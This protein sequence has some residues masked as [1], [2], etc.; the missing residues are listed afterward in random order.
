MDFRRFL[1]RSEELVLPFLG[2]GTVSTGERR[3]TVEGPRPSPGWVRFRVEGRRATALGAADAP[4]L[5]GLP[6]RTGHFVEGYLA[7]SDG[8]FQRLH[9]LPEDEPLV[10]SPIRA[11]LWHDGALLF[12][13]S[14]F[15]SDVEEATRRCLEEGRAISGEKGVVPSLRAA[16]AIALGV[17]AARRLGVDVAP[18]ELGSKVREIAT[19]GLPEAEAEVRRIAQR[20]DDALRARSDETRNEALESVARHA[21]ARAAARPARATLEDAEERAERALVAATGMLL[22]S[23]RLAGNRL[24]VRYELFGERF[25]TVVDAL[26][27]NVDD[28]GVCL[29]GSDSELTLESLPSV[30]REAIDTGVLVI[31]RR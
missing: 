24:E 1:A 25:V 10:F 16:F 21:A 26:T 2:G 18:A 12:S 15:E 5:E 14:I 28:A 7:S 30:I 3:L 11:R 23:R 27:L 20:R 31:T 8:T 29:D 4:D 19:G 6:S 9:L 17:K 22:S 13:E